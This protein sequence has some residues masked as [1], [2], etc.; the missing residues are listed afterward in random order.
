MV[1]WRWTRPAPSHGRGGGARR[2]AVGPVWRVRDAAARGGDTVYRDD[3]GYDVVTDALLYCV[4]GLSGSLAALLTT[5]GLLGVFARLG[6]PAGRTGRVGL[7]LAYVALALAVLSVAGLV[8]RFDP[9]F[10]APR[11]FGSLA[12]GAATVLTGVDTLRAGGAWGWAD[13]LVAAGVRRRG[14][15]GGRWGRDHRAVRPGL[16]AGGLP[17]EVEL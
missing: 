4:Y 14:G 12:L 16:G 8:V 13:A 7:V 1:E 3:R 15:A 9:L 2:P 17:A 10:T 5:L 11:I 6:L